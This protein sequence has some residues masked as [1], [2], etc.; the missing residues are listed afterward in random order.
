MQRHLIKRWDGLLFRQF[1]HRKNKVNA[2]A[3]GNI[4]NGGER[5]AQLKNQG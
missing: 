4:Q 1:D 5:S 2:L 3:G